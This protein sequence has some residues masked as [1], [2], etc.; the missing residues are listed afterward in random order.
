MLQI[1]QYQKNGEMVVADLP[2]PSCLPGGVLIRTYYSLIS[3]GTEKISVTNTQSSLI[4]RARKQPEQVRQVMSMVKKEGLL[5]TVK[6]VQSKLESYKS[7]G[8]SISGVVLESDCSEFQVGDRVTAG[9]AGYANH[10]EFIAVPKNLVV[11]LPENVSFESASYTTLGAIAMQGFRQ[12]EPSLGETVV[13]IGLGLLGQ[14]TIQLLRAAGC[15]VVGLDINESLFERAKKYGAELALP[16]NFSSTETIK[17]FTRGYGADSV[18]VTAST[19][20]NE[21]LELAFDICRKK[22]KVVIV[23]AV[24]MN[25]ERGAFYTKE[26]DLRISCSYGPGRYDAN[27]EERGNDYPFAYVRWTENRNMQA[28]IDLISQGRIDVD[29]MTSHKFNIQNAIDAY[30][31]ITGKN[32]QPHLGILL[33]YPER[34]NNNSKSI[35][36]NKFNPKGDLSI[37]FIGAG[38]FATNN[39]LPPLKNLVDNFVSVSTSTPVNAKTAAEKFGFAEATTDSISIINNPKI[40]LIFIASRHDSHSKFVVE[41]L[42]QNK[43][44][45][46]EKPLAV[47]FEQLDQI[48]EA[49]IKSEAGLMVGFNRRFSKSFVS[50]KEFLKSRKSQ[51]LMN[52]RVNAGFI[53]KSHWIYEPSQGGRIIGEVCHFI[54]TMCYLTN[55]LPVRVFAQAISSDNSAVENYDNVILN[56]KF[57][58]GSIGTISYLANGDGSLDKEYFEVHC[59]RKSAV[60]NNFDSV[61]LYANGKKQSLKFDGKKGIIEEV[62]MTI[63]SIMNRKNSPIDADT[64]FAVTRATFLS[65]ESLKTG[66]SIEIINN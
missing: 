46:V 58:D 23:G 24:G 64:L 31:I 53:P 49:Y 34:V 14:I 8:Y 11:H 12:A 1:I 9:G 66:Q 60:M 56:I 39:L 40:N 7:L 36:I 18:I 59:E 10:A 17:A 62:E 29:S 5:T 22:G 63:N 15:R 61:E 19:L 27:Y 20:S 21:P 55:S 45:F 28:F 43:H 38:N 13:V 2:T 3:A 4:G 50:I 33:E 35:K 26:I 47:S 48:I 30:D 54:D 25:L 41:A 65:I 42:K 32:N 51:M 52:Y 37:G 6:K 44:V 16:S 57:A